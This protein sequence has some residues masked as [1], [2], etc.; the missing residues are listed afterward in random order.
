MGMYDFKIRKKNLLRPRNKQKGGF[1][2]L[3]RLTGQI[4]GG[5]PLTFGCLPANG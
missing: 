1:G 2:P 5:Y 4:S 3:G